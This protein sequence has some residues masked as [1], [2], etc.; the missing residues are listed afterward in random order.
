MPKGASSKTSSLEEFDVSVSLSALDAITEKVA[1]SV[2]Q[3]IGQHVAAALA[4]AGLPSGEGAT[5]LPAQPVG[6]AAGVSS[7]GPP[8]TVASNLISKQ[9]RIFVLKKIVI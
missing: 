5:V 7:R 1:A 8:R 2:Q 9:I 4:R 6:A 3:S